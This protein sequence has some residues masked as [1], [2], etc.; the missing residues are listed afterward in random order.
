[1]N[2][3]LVKGLL[4]LEQLA[5]ADRPL[6]VTELAQ[7]LDISKSNVHRLLQALLELHY[8]QQDDEAAYRTTLRLW[9]L[10]SLVLAHFDVK[11]VAQPFMERLL[12]Q[13]RETVHLSVLDGEEVVY[14][15]KLDSPEAVRAYSEIGGRAPA[16]CVATGKAL[17]AQQDPD[18]LASLSKRLQPHSRHTLT[19]PA[20]FLQEMRRVREQGYATNRGEWRET[21]FGLAAAVRDANGKAV[22]A[23][24]ISGPSARLKA[25]M[26]KALSTP[27]MAAAAEVS[28]ALAG[29][30]RPEMAPL[31]ERMRR[32][33]GA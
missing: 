9:E 18:W 28:A 22:A 12:M 20:Q 13:T 27:V 14:V 32:R 8:V 5:R 19:D 16:H 26:F 17:L 7:R 25:S 21:V 33:S 15:H 4:L 10:G 11:R 3:T 6:G 1:M 23:I 24:G 31:L 30:K 2:N 29:G